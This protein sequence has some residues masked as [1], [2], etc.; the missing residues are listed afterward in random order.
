MQVFPTRDRNEKVKTAFLL[1]A[2]TVSIASAAPVIRVQ[3]GSAELFQAVVSRPLSAA[4]AAQFA[5]RRL[6]ELDSSGR[7]IATVPAVIDTSSGVPEL[8]CMLPGLTAPGA[9]RTLALSDAAPE[10]GATQSDLEVE[11]D[12]AFITIRNSYFQL[13]HPVKGRGGLPRNIIFQLSGQKDDKLYL[14]DRVFRRDTREQLMAGQDESATARVVYSSPLRVVVE[15][16]TR[17]VRQAKTGQGNP[18]AVYRFVYSPYSPMVDVTARF[19]KDDDTVWDELHFLHLTRNDFHYTNFIIGEPPKV[20]P[21]QTPGVKSTGHSARSWALMATNSDA[22]GVGKGGVTCWDASDE[23]H[24]YVCPN[25]I[26]WKDR[27]VTRASAL[28][29]GPATDPSEYSRWLSPKPSTRVSLINNGMVVDVGGPDEAVPQGAHELTNDALRMVFSDAKH[30]FD[31]LGIENRLA[32]NTRFVRARKDVPGLWEIEFRSPYKAVAERNTGEAY[33]VVLLDNHAEGKLAAALHARTL[34]LQWKH[35][36]LGD[37]KDVVDVTATILLPNGG[38]P[39]E[40]RIDVANRS[41]RYGVYE[42]RFPYLPSVNR[43]GLGTTLVPG[44]NWGGE[45][46][47]AKGRWNLAYP[48]TRC[49]VQCMGFMHNHAGLYF[50]SHDPGARTKTLQIS[51]EQDATISVLAENATI[52]GNSQKS[53]FPFVIAADTGDWWGAARLYR[54]WATQQSWCRK[55]WIRDRNDI[56]ERLKDLGFWW[57][58][59]GAPDRVGPLLLT[60]EK[61]CGD[62]NIGTHWYNWHKIPF[63]NSYPEYFPTKPRFAEVTRQLTARNQI[64]M[65]YINGRLWDSAIESFKKTGLAGSCKQPSGENYIEVYGSGRKLSPMCPTTKI[66]Q[67]KMAEV[68]HRL[69][70]EYGVNGIYYDQIGAARPKPC[71][72]PSH[73]HP[74]GGGRHWVDGYRKMLA[75]I[76]VEAA[77]AGCVMT[78]ENTAEPYMDNIDAYLAWIPRYDTDVP[79][80]PAVYSGYTIYFTSPQAPQDDLDAYAQAQGR[81]FLWGCQLGWNATWML[82]DQHREK[83]DFMLKASRLR[84]A[85]R[86]YML[87]GQLLDEVRPAELVPPMTT[88]WNR[89]TPHVATLPSVMGTIWRSVDGQLAVAMVNT[90]GTPRTFVY[91]VTPKDL[92]PSS[93]KTA[94]TW[95]VERL[96]EHGTMPTDFVLGRSIC[97]HETLAP[98]E[99]RVLTI[100]PGTT[101]TLA[102]SVERAK[103]SSDDPILKRT[104]A[105]FLFDRAL[106]DRGIR[107]DVPS[108]NQVL[109]RGEPLDLT[110]QVTT[111]R[112]PAEFELDCRGSTTR[113]S[114][115]AGSSRSVVRQLWIEEDGD[116][117]AEIT[118][119]VRLPEANVQRQ[120]VVHV[121]FVPTV[122]VQVSMPSE[123]YGGQSFL[124]PVVVRN[125]SRAMRQG[126]I[127]LQVPNTWSI[128]PAADFTVAQLAPGA[129]RSYLLTCRTP[130]TKA[131]NRVTFSAFFA[132]RSAPVSMLIRKSRPDGKED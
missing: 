33:E 51:D 117:E 54:A 89:R 92:L 26:S 88:I 55:G 93:E 110:F 47:D 124:L 41:T 37:E 49:P 39:S 65:P 58:E 114:V 74:L 7:I 72:D 77:R 71:Y 18:R 23:F 76:K 108:V 38:A 99:I 50:A 121:R 20:I 91:T 125:N 15:T 111:T 22:A 131:D 5:S 34:T 28:Y 16:R 83:L 86:K 112:E 30:G 21:M 11:T 95:L 85:A 79:L 123:A 106:A 36:D 17:F 46:R 25:R 116:G 27:V 64:V 29:F 67:D 127:I 4:Q 52:P 44:G 90:C 1:L 69:I 97:R 101:A 118:A 6:V 128:R 45:L 75:P 70:H 130:R 66:W 96:T 78:T 60:A 13:Q 94:D 109:V 107:L 59:S 9:L 84:V 24:Y 42:T 56:P 129:M 43:R 81:D 53:E 2:L 12:G 19:E 48:S 3:N 73:G 80:L 104:A 35:L 122:S 32:G 100:Q 57:I 119:T 62:L 10:H 31:C 120:Y 115:P 98:H 102:D 82:E 40:W 113:A 14:L 87:L 63:D 8:V 132:E 61:R 105:E 126:R 68:S 103:A